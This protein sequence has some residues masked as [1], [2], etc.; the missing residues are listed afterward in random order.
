MGR[1][2]EAENHFKAAIAAD[3]ALSEPYFNLAFLA[4][5]GGH[6]DEGL[7]LYQTALE[8]GALPDP[9]LEARLAK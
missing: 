1:N 6:K 4:E 9:E 2:S 7:K 8:N 3:P 5:S